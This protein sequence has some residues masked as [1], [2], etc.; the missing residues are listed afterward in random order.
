[1]FSLTVSGTRARGSSG[2]AFSE[3][4]VHSRSG[5]TDLVAQHHIHCVDNWDDLID[6]GEVGL[7]HLGCCNL[8]G[9]DHARQIDRPQVHNSFIGSSSAPRTA[10]HCATV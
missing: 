1:M 4:P 10:S 6:A 7:D 8:A 3:H 9:A 2:P 5:R